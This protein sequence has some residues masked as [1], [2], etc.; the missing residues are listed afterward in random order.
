M[1]KKAVIILVLILVFSTTIT[2]SAGS[3]WTRVQEFA[4]QFADLARSAGFPED[5]G[6]IKMAQ[7]VFK[8]KS[9]E[10]V[11][12]YH[13]YVT[14][15]D[16]YVYNNPSS[17]NGDNTNVIIYPN[18]NV[19][20]GT[21]LWYHNS[22]YDYYYY[23]DSDGSKVRGTPNW[24][25]NTTTPTKDNQTEYNY[26][27]KNRNLY[28]GR[29]FGVESYV[30]KSDAEY[31]AKFCLSLAPSWDLKTWAATDWLVLNAKGT[32]EFA[33]IIQYFPHY[34]D[35][36][37]LTTE[38]GKDAFN[39]AYEIL[40][41]KLAEDAGNTYVGRILPTNYSYYRIEN[42]NIYFCTSLDGAGYTFPD[43]NTSKSKSYLHSPY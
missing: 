34:N 3:N 14:N 29:I 20:D 21:N 19:W 17:D 13:S 8:S 25:S 11:G 38:K 26:S 43:Y 32:R 37:D 30:K 15:K 42:G 6:I 22:R 18:G 35:K 4:H 39:L 36:V 16:Y 1:N 5:S 41:R 10:L 31:L 12:Y 27:Y 2:V 33:D 7:D 24:S 40:F 28:S 9:G 23:F